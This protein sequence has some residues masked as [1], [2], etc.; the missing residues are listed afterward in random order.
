MNELIF[1]YYFI[2]IGAVGTCKL[3]ITSSPLIP[4]LSKIVSKKP[5]NNDSQTFENVGFTSYTF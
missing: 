5:S 4:D 1:F 3:D 2:A